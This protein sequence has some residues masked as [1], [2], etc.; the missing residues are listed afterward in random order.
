MLLLY[1]Y[2]NRKL[3][4]V[5]SPLGNMK[6]DLI[7]KKS[8]VA[9]SG[10]FANQ[11]YKSGMVVLQPEGRIL[12]S[13]DIDWETLGERS[14]YYLQVS[15]WKYLEPSDPRLEHLNHACNPNLGYKSLD[16]KVSFVAIKP[17]RRG[18]E[19]TF[20]YSTTMLEEWDEDVSTLQK[21]NCGA[22]NCRGSIKDFRNI[23]KS[24]QDRYAKL[25]VVPDY[26][27]N[28]LKRTKS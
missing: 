26:I 6:K 22:R 23:P 3:Y 4:I 13:R 8:K 27:L 10:L 5:A 11:S 15:P 7:I 21:C 9:G 12:H 20:D 25:G 2:N 1:R 19:V 28:N 14:M 24:D 18:D 16:G 17:V